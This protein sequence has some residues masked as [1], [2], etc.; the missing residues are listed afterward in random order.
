VW[1]QALRILEEMSHPDADGVRDKLNRAS[2]PV[3][4]LSRP[5]V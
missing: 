1:R 2:T 3:S 4:S 5:T